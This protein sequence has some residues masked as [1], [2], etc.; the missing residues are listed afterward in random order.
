MALL[1]QLSVLLGKE[2]KHISIIL[3]GED[4]SSYNASQ[5]DAVMYSVHLCNYIFCMSVSGV[6]SVMK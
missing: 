6:G 1:G 3:T 2:L 4:T 5:L